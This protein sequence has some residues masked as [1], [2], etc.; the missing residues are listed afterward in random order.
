MKPAELLE[1]N[2]LV[3]YLENL[4]FQEGRLLVSIAETRTQ[5]VEYS[6]NEHSSHRHVY[7]VEVI[8]DPNKILDQ[9]SGDEHTADAGNENDTEHQA[10][11]RR[12]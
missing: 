9:I 11:Q 10:Q 12:N 7:L 6:S 1:N 2:R 8:E 3:A 4:P 5:L